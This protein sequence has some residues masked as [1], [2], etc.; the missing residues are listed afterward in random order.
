MVFI[1]VAGDGGIQCCWAHLTCNGI[2]MCKFFDEGLFHGC[3]RYE[4]NVDAMCE[5]WNQEL[6][7]NEREAGSVIGV[8]P[9]Q[10]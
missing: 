4:P 3:K 6:D 5:L 1:L 10:V 2:N 7:A 9:Q 8:I